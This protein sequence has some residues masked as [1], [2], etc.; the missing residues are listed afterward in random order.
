MKTAKDKRTDMQN[1][2]K[3][4]QLTH[5]RV[6]INKKFTKTERMKQKVR[7]TRRE[8]KENISQS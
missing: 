8:R 7:S 2:A 1:K 6:Y 3:I 5:I 4:K